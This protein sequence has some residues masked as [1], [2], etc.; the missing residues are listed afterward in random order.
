MSIFFDVYIELCPL[1]YIK[2]VEIRLNTML[3]FHELEYNLMAKI[4]SIDLQKK[5]IFDEGYAQ[6]YEESQS[7]E[8]VL[9]FI[10]KKTLKYSFVVHN[11]K[12]LLVHDSTEIISLDI[13]K[14]YIIRLGK[15][16]TWFIFG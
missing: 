7:Q 3:F 8:D 10:F 12:A 13:S 2:D 15:R 6:I 9:P 14:K 16:S 1:L 11:S 4:D 5:C